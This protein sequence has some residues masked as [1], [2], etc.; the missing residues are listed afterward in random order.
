MFRRTIRT[1]QNGQ[2]SFDNLKPGL[3]YLI[4]M[5]QEYEFKPNSHPIQISDGYHM[6]LIVEADRVAYS[7][8]GKVTSINGQAESDV[9][10]EAV[11]LRSQLDSDTEHDVCKTSRENSPVEPGFGTYRIRN[12][13]PNC[14]YELIVKPVKSEE[15][16]QANKRAFRIVPK[17][18]LL[19][20]NNSDVSDKNF[21]IIDQI[22]KVDVSL[23][24]TYKSSDD[25]VVP[26]NPKKL[27]NFARV[28]LFR[29]NQP[30]VIIQTQYA[31]ANSIV[32]FNSLP[33][34]ENQ[35]YSIQVELLMPSTVSI[36]GTL[37]QHQQTQL[38]Q[39]PVIER[40]ESSFYADSAHKHL[41]AR[42]VLDKKRVNRMFMI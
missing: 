6:N 13:K 24:I 23:G 33:R 36:F 21:V 12:L 17:N 28:K 10:V 40:T 30:E 29:T 27:N 41:V 22:E 14:E 3:Y 37:N 5:M 26:V 25:V 9:L 8:F 39:Q 38:S 19:K 35:Q 32:Y 16:S 31:P 2:A 7:C 4:V 11:G 42:F 15:V 1:D 34:E 18:I 20:L